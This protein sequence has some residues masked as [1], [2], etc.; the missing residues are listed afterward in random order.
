MKL[1]HTTFGGVES[2]C[3]HGIQQAAVA[4]THDHA[5]RWEIM[6]GCLEKKKKIT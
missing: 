6:D 3:K 5:T 1:G 2:V 4:D